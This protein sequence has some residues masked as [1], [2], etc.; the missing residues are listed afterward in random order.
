[1]SLDQYSLVISEMVI[2]GFKGYPCEV[3]LNNRIWGDLQG[4]DKNHIWTTIVQHFFS[5]Y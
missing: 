5:M 3:N 1:M 4:S 2:D